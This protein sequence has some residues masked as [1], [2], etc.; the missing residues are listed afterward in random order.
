MFNDNGIYF[1]Q[2]IQTCSKLLYLLVLMSA[3]FNFLWLHLGNGSTCLG[4]NL[5][6][7]LI[8]KK[9]CGDLKHKT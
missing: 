4:K 2:N 1:R 5:G 3:L 6:L 8:Q 9:V 7:G